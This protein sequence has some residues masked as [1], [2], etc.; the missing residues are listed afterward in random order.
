MVLQLLGVFLSTLSQ[1]PDPAALRSWQAAVAAS[2]Q[3]QPPDSSK[4][5]QAGQQPT[6]SPSQVDPRDSFR[7]EQQPA[8][9]AGNQSL[10]PQFANYFQIPNTPVILKFNAKPRVD[11][12]YDNHNS[13]N[14][15]R[16]VTAQIPTSTDPDQGGPNRFNINAKGSQL[17]IDLRAPSVDGAPRFYFQ[18]D[19][20]GPGP[21][22]FP[23]RIRQ[24]YGQIYNIIVGMTFSVFEDPD[25]WPDTVDYEG[26]N[27]TIFAR[28]PLARFLLPLNEEWQLNFGI[29]QPESEID[30]SIDPDAAGVNRSPEIGMNVRW[31]RKETGH[32]QLAVMGR[33]LGVRGPIVG[34]QKALGWGA[35]LA[36][37]VQTFGKDSLQLQGTYGE[38]IFRYIND[39]FVNNDAAFD[40]GGHLEPIPCVAGMIGYT[41]HWSEEWRSTA[42]YG[43]VHL[44]NQ[45]SQ[46]PTAYHITHYASVNLVWQIKKRLSLGVEGLYGSKEDNAEN[47]GNVVRV[48]FGLLYS[49]L[50]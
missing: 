48:Q 40:S 18:N 41:H 10:D 43:Y 13:G 29:E 33:Q 44:R 5:P 12:T 31:E 38:G 22:E 45:A 20:F 34:S 24:L 3:D 23:L 35:N 17:S 8:P 21:G 14:E 32:L 39:D 46:G 27:S 49:L 11:M 42:T 6:G 19:F 9:R 47:R 2:S 16:F 15:D 36:V 50:E 4:K 1:E 26:P 7:N 28:R 25:A 37:V 30:T